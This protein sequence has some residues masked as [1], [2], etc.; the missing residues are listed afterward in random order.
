[1]SGPPDVPDPVDMP[2][3]AGAGDTAGEFGEPV[4]AERLVGPVERVAPDLLGLLLVGRGLVARVVEVEGYDEDDPA[5]HTHHGRTD[6]NATMF[7]PPGRLY[8]YLSHGLHHCGN[9]AVGPRGVGAAVLLRALAVERGGPVALRRREGR[10]ADD[11]RLLAGGPGRVGQV[12]ALDRADDGLDLLDPGAGMVLRDDGQRP[13]H[14]VTGP[15]VGVRLA[16]DR[17]W[18]WWVADHPAVSRYRRHPRA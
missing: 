2:D 14:V 10:G 12:L 6:A 18:R 3:P 7:G 1:V 4:P 13:A 15:R 11:P 9:V 16:A 17:P 5:S 8:V